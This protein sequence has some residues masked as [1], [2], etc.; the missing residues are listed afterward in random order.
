[1][2][3]LCELCG[4]RHHAYRAHVFATNRVATNAAPVVRAGDSAG[5]LKEQSDGNRSGRD[6]GSMEHPEE[7]LQRAAE[8]VAQVAGS[9]SAGVQRGLYLNEQEPG[10]VPS[11]QAGKDFPKPLEDDRM[12]RGVDGG[13]SDQV[14]TLNR[15]SRGAYNAYQREYMR[16]RRGSS[17]KVG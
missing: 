6:S 12:E 10:V 4:E 1:L 3:P 5:F 7:C 2:I 13:G 11:P 17:R 15:R 14:K 16:K 9:G 8:A